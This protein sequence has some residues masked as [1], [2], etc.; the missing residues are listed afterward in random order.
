MERTEIAKMVRAK[1]VVITGGEPTLYDL[2]DLLMALYA[3]NVYT[4]V[5]TS[6]QNEFKGI[7]RPDWLTVSPKEK[8]G[9]KMPWSIMI[10]ADEVKWVVDD[11]LPYWIIEQS[12]KE[13]EAKTVYP[14]FYLMPEGNPPGKRNVERTLE[15]LE[16]ANNNKWRYTDR[17]QT[18]IGVR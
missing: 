11:N 15:Y 8:L 4:Q 14:L 10:M 5:E 9:W 13:F 7:V 1:H 12:W 18:R 6:G 17:L 2:D 3:A 16:M